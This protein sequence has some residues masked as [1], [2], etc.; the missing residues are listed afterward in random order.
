[1]RLFRALLD[2][3]PFE[4]AFIY[5]TRLYCWTFDKKLRLYNTSDIESALVAADLDQGAATSYTL[6]HSRGI[7]ASSATIGHWRAAWSREAPEAEP[8]LLDAEAVPYKTLKVDADSL[9]LLDMMIFYGRLYMATADALLAVTP[10]DPDEP[11]DRLRM[12]VRVDAPCYAVSGGLGAVAASCADRG[13]YLLLDDKGWSGDRRTAQKAASQSF[14]SE[15]GF[16][17]VVNHRF[18]GEVEFL[19][20]HTQ[21]TKDGRVLTSVRPAKIPKPNTDNAAARETAAS[22]DLALWDQSRLVTFGQGRLASVSVIREGESR[23]LNRTRSLGSY[24][25]SDQYWAP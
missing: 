2:R 16:G 10:F 3:A 19:A 12:H 11:P 7:G 17:S 18:R 23:S 22:A 13:L 6:F 5:G 15:I 1:M 8:L 4:D 24:D 20:G 9:D 14:R 21:E 25:T